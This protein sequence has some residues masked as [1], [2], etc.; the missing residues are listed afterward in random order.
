[1]CSIMCVQMQFKNA[2]QFPN[3]KY[4]MNEK[5]VKNLHKVLQS[6]VKSI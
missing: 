3:S 1:M 4:S 5:T 2:E 6:L